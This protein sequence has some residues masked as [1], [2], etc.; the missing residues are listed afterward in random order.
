MRKP[1]SSFA[2]FALTITLSMI[3]G[4]WAPLVLSQGVP[5]EPVS[6]ETSQ[7][8]VVNDERYSID[9][10]VPIDASAMQEAE[11]AD[12]TRVLV[13][14]GESDPLGA[15]Y[16]PTD[17]SNQRATRY[18]PQF[19]GSADAVCP[20]DQVA[21]ATLTGD[22]VIWVAAA[23]EMDLRQEELVEIGQTSDGQAMF[24]IP[25]DDQVVNLFVAN[26]SG[27]G[28]NSLVRYTQVNSENTPAQLAGG[29]V[30]AGQEFT[31]TP[32]AVSSLDG[33]VKVGCAGLFPLFASAPDQPFTTVALQVNGA[34]ASYEGAPPT[35]PAADIPAE[36]STP[37]PATPEVTQPPATAVPP[38]AVPPTEVPPTAVPPT[39]VP[40]TAVPPTEV[41]PTAVPPTEV[42]PTEVPPTTVPPTE[43]PPTAVPP[44]AVP[45]T[46][47][48]PTAA[49]AVVVPPVQDVA[50]AEEGEVEPTAVPPTPDP[51]QPTPTPL[52]ARPTPTPVVYQAP[53]AV[54]TASVQVASTPA[55]QSTA[56]QCVGVIGSMD[57]DN[58]PSH[59]PRQLQFAGQSY[60]F[61]EAVSSSDLGEQ[62]EVSC[63]GP[64]VVIEIEGSDTLYLGIQNSTQT[65]YAFEKSAAFTVQAQ[66][67]DTQTPQRLSMPDTD[68]GP[69][70]K[71][72]AVDPLVPMSYSSV[73][74]VL[75]VSNADSST[76][77]RI[78]GHSVSDDAFGE[79]VPA[80]EAE[81]ASQE[82]IDK[83]AQ[84]GIP[85]QFVIGT[86]Q[87]VLVALWTPFG[88]TTNGWLT[89]YGVDGE[90]APDQ[91]V[92]L[93]PRQ[94][95]CLV[96][97]KDD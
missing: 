37:E 58:I 30:F 42:P 34:A 48:P 22:G 4:F 43:V 66:T 52:V 54:A 14:P 32:G 53:A 73:S 70:A 91:L 84:H 67:Y 81:A 40:P 10:E 47:V 18:L 74:M 50:G 21:A 49:P 96:F 88:T 26:N 15:V 55:L 80:G 35:E 57:D 63:V 39:E 83:A 64:F 82:V 38:T 71:Y 1:F 46:E 69:G 11:A 93:D 33:L 27:Q 5:I 3:M 12:G 68:E 29:F 89:L 51:A 44:T 61:T 86:Q 6:V 16:V 85:A 59:L 8:L 41:P 90:A 7:E 79:Y 75:Y 65:L 31:A 2:T 87:Y 20:V 36:P 56:L 60:A 78:L 77:D 19:V 25:G 94:T 76:H 9:L 24:G 17:E 23:P 97:N 95:N 45:A 28:P 72:R 13:K 92:G 62:N